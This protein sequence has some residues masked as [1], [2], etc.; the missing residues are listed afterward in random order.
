[1]LLLVPGQAGSVHVPHPATPERSR[2]PSGGLEL[3]C[4]RLDGKVC[5]KA[6]PIENT[7]TN[8]TRLRISRIEVSREVMHVNAYSLFDQSFIGKSAC[9]VLPRFSIEF[10]FKFLFS[11]AFHF[12][13][14]LTSGPESRSWLSLYPIRK[15]EPFR[16]QLSPW[17]MQRLMFRKKWPRSCLNRDVSAIDNN[18]W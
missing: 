16:S 15:W 2:L 8:F 1:M 13:V 5:Q 12:D 3:V 9:L 7:L 14:E 11:D 17:I 4:T 10:L 18:D 6:H